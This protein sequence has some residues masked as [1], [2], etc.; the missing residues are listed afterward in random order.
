M[1]QPG[2]GPIRVGVIGCGA[3]AQIAHLP[4]LQEL[5]DRFT[6]AA[7]CD[8][9][10][11][12]LAAVGDQY[13][14][15]AHARFDDYRA[16]CASD[17]VD[18]VMVCHSGSH[19]PPALAALHARKHVIIE[20][21]LTS[22]VAEAEQLAAAAR[23]ARATWGGVTLMAYM[24]QFDAGFQYVQ[25]LLSP[26]L[27]AGQITYVDARHI[28]AHNPLYEAHHTL[29]KGTVPEHIRNAP[30]PSPDPAEQLGPNPSPSQL[31]VL[32]GI[33][34]SIHDIYCLR[35]LLGPPESILASQV[36]P[37]GRAALFRYPRNV[38]VNYAWIDIGP[39]RNFRQEF[40]LYGPDIHVSLRFP[41]PYRRSAPTEVVVNE[42]EPPPDV[43]AHLGR[44][45]SLSP[46]LHGPPLAEKRITA[47]Y[48]DAY[49]L[50][51]VHFHAC[52]TQGVEALATIDHA[53]EDTR[54]FVEW[55]TATK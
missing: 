53:L 4:F 31:R 12:T 54:F 50:E 39:V 6:I 18:A 32:T 49:K 7:L 42:M 20:K 38:L 52:I 23:E 3:I 30:R 51:W 28:H 8:V 27:A 14:V 48:Q 35:T 36:I 17:L 1:S 22:S 37:A 47:S 46:Q 41:Q 55:A 33:G 21:P 10:P 45:S 19:V 11:D 9:V 15:P 2:S 29:W 25:R 13:R 40:V 16:L 44:D 43:S 24:K 26:R 5:R 34:S